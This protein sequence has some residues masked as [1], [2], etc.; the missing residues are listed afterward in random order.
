MTTDIQLARCVLDSDGPYS[1]SHNSSKSPHIP[2]LTIYMHVH[3]LYALIY[4]TAHSFWTTMSHAFR[5]F[6]MRTTCPPIASSDVLSLQYTLMKRTS[7]DALYRK[8][9]W[10]TRARTYVSKAKLFLE[11]ILV[12]RRITP[13][14]PNL[15]PIWWWVVGFTLCPLYRH[16]KGHNNALNLRL[17]G[18]QSPS[19]HLE[20][21]K[22]SGL[23]QESK[24]DAQ[25]PNP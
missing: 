16:R 23:F 17:G 12:N 20:K 24:D 4:Q 11:G 21:T 5:N 22:I 1:L 2:L 14:I 25:L 9:T 10:Q 18:S 8:I 13:L 6:L 19:R 15:R 3:T 7:C